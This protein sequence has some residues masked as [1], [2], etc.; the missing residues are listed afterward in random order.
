ML[1][2]RAGADRPRPPPR[3]PGDEVGARAG[4]RARRRPAPPRP[5]GRLPG[6]AR[7]DRAGARARLRRHRL[8]DGR[9]ALGRRAAPLRPGRVRA[10]RAPRAGSPPGRRGSDPRAMADG[11]DPPRARR[12]AG[13]RR[14]LAARPR[15]A[16]AV[17]APL[18]SGMGRLFDAV[19]SVL[20]VRD[21]ITYEGQAA[22]ELEQ[23]AGETTRRAVRVARS[24]T[25]RRSSPSSKPTSPTGGRAP[26]SRQPSTRRSQPPRRPPAR[27]RRRR[28]RS[29]ALRRQRSRTSAC[30]PPPAAGSRPTASACCR[31]ASSRRTTAGSA[32]D[33]RPSAPRGRAS[34]R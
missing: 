14:A 8:R 16:L 2:V 22:I 15:D 28:A 25:A 27:G 5:R 29:S 26:R 6:G 3:V 24:A 11:G 10:R 21:E 1:D 30:S 13:R 18:S 31:T 32:T 4:R 19:A 17:N 20:G 12:A 7:R 33:R 23:L 9:D 34:T